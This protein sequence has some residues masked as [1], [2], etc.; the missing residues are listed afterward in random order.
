MSYFLSTARLGFRWSSDDLAIAMNLWGDPKV[1]AMIDVRGQLSPAEVR[2]ILDRHI[3]IQRHAGVQYW[4]MFARETGEHVGCCGLRPYTATERTFELGAHIVPKFWRQG[5][6]LEAANAVIDYAFHHLGAA[7]LVAGH[8][9][10]NRAS[11]ALLHKLGFQQTHEE[12]Y[13]PTGLMH[14][15]YRLKSSEFNRTRG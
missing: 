5:Y 7:Q 12:F 15:M 3:A 1:M 10:N 8:N 9:P 13:A 11:R 6:A 4:P 2:E 14:P